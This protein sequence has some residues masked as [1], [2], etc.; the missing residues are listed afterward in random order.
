MH[1]RHWFAVRE[2]AAALAT[3][4]LGEVEEFLNCYGSGLYAL[5]P[6]TPT[7]IEDEAKRFAPLLRFPAAPQITVG[8]LFAGTAQMPV[9]MLL[10]FR[11]R[12]FERSVVPWR[13]EIDR[14]E[15]VSCR[16]NAGHRALVPDTA[17]QFVSGLERYALT[18]G[19][20]AVA[21]ASRVMSC[22]KQEFYGRFTRL[23]AAAIPVGEARWA[24]GIR[25]SNDAGEELFAPV[26]VVGAERDPVGFVIDGK[27]HLFRP[28]TIA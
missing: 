24:A 11:D 6:A 27:P 13:P 4:A 14:P 5:G 16:V 10:I 22:P 2:I 12:V 18:I 8:I 17:H 1:H 15:C 28:A 19:S 9:R 26:L 23:D 3:R 21:S 20:K 7:V 25:M